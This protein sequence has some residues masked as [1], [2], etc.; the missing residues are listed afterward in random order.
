VSFFKPAGDPVWGRDFSQLEVFARNISMNYVAIG[1]DLVIGVMMLPF[2]IAHLGQS[3][4]GLWVLIASVTMY[5]SILDLGYGVSQVKFASEYRARRDREGLNQIVSSLFFFFCVIGLAAFAVGVLLSMNLERFFSLTPAQAGDGRDV[6]LIISAY[7]ALGFPA[8]VFGGIVNGFQRH[9]LNGFVSIGT[10]I[11]V[12]VVNLAVLSAGYGLVELVAA[13]TT[14][15]ALSYAGY[16]MNAYRAF[17]GL[18]IRLSKVRLP[19]LREVTGFSVFILLIDL[20]NKVNYSTDTIVIGA[21]M[22]TAAIAVWAV[23]QRLIDATQT[24]TGQLTGAL[25]PIV[26]DSSALGREDRLRELFIQG[27]RVSLAMVIPVVTGLSLLA[28][29]LVMAWVGPEFSGSIAVIYI[30]AMAVA[31]R[32][33]NST[34]TTLLKGAGRHRLLAIS[35]VLVAILNIGFSIALVRRM[36]LAGVA[37][38]T[39]MALA[40]VSSLVLFPAA[41]RRVQMNKREALR[42]GVFPA[43]WPAVVMAAFLAITRTVL[44]GNL[45]AIALQA[46]VGGFIYLGVFL[47]LAIGRDERE[48]YLTKAKRLL[49]RPR[50][51]AEIQV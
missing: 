46:I 26:V 23:A 45:V 11:V 7:L 38:G 48:W 31:I 29:P 22:S 10:S 36:G 33:G 4:Y 47:M 2:N 8:S 19:R 6:L 34:A 41:C 17:P 5:F 13:T 18:R 1:V 40:I 27:T 25:F 14:I 44:S 24:I 39:L 16:T 43:L 9:Y 28:E 50:V 37:L 15:R 42:I 35:N 32:V 30:L 3:T 51:A 12:A 21:F 49:N 20:A